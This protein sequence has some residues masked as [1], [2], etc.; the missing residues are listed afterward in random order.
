MTASTDMTPE[1]T[2][3]LRMRQLRYPIR[4]QNRTAIWAGVAVAGLLSVVVVIWLSNQS[5]SG[6]RIVT[7]APPKAPTAATTS[8]T[9]VKL[10]PRPP[11]VGS[12]DAANFKTTSNTGT[13]IELVGISVYPPDGTWWKP[14]GSVQTVPAPQTHESNSRP[15][16]DMDAYMFYVRAS[17]NGQQVVQI[18]KFTPPG[19]YFYRQGMPNDR[20]ISV[21]VAV[22][23]QGAETTDFGMGI[24]LP[25]S[26]LERIADIR[27]QAARQPHEHVING[28]RGVVKFSALEETVGGSKLK[29]EYVAGKGLSPFASSA[30]WLML[31]DTGNRAIYGRS[32]DEEEKPD[33]SFT[34]WYDFEVAPGAVQR[35][36]YGL[37]PVEYAEF[38]NVSLRPGKITKANILAVRAASQD[39]QPASRPATATAPVQ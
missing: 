10:K 11:V 30:P 32:R 37:R 25:S 26:A 9:V 17:S 19:R 34:K 33:G 3:W 36:Q 4:M 23:P 16:G 15:S 6:S 13:S 39:A 5:L 31:Y 1:S 14:D 18:P 22:V 7:V 12:I 20:K 2:V 29:L 38:Q 8:A 35:L 24:Q 27:G 28:D 21:I